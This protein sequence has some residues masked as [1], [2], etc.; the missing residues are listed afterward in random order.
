[1]APET[2]VSFEEKKQKAGRHGSGYL[3][4]DRIE[5]R[6]GVVSPVL[7]ED[8]ASSYQLLFIPRPVS[9]IVPLALDTVVYL[10]RTDNGDEPIRRYSHAV[11]KMVLVSPIGLTGPG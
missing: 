4:E 2:V 9:R 5:P 1:M 10:Q 11:N 7:S 8:E 6:G 3:A